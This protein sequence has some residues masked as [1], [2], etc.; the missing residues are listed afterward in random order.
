MEL[1]KEHKN[2]VRAF[3]NERRATV[4]RWLQDMTTEAVRRVVQDLKARDKFGQEGRE[5]WK[6]SDIGQ[7]QDEYDNRIFR[8]RV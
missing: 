1:S 7:L 2:H 4:K 5:G 8:N 6:I 3:E